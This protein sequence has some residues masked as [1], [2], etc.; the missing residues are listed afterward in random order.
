[1][2]IEPKIVTVSTRHGEI[3]VERKPDNSI[4]I[5]PAMNFAKLV[6]ACFKPDA[7]RS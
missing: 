3:V 5:S 6:E 4:R 2:Q 1:M 7:D